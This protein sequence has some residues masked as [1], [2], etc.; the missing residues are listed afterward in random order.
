MNELTEF[1]QQVRQWLEQNCPVSMRGAAALDEIYRGGSRETFSSDEAKLWFER[2]LDKGWTAPGWPRKYGGADLS[3][4]QVKVLKQEM[5]R[6]GC[7]APLEAGQGLAMLG[8]ALLEFGTEQQKLEHLPRI[9]RGE[10]RWCQ[11]YSEPGAGSD[12]ANVQCRAKDMGDHFLIN[13]TKIWTSNADVADWIFCLVRTD[14][15]AGKQEGISFL[16]VDMAQPGVSVKPIELISG[17]S[18]FCQV[19]LDDVRAEKHNLIGEINQGW[20]VGKRLLQ[21]ER[22]LMSEIGDLSMGAASDLPECA[23]LYIGLENGK[24]AESQLRMRV[25]Q[26]EM[27]SQVL[28]LAQRKAFEEAKSGRVN[29]AATSFFK[30]YAT[31]QQSVR[32]ELMLALMGER[33]LGWEHKRMDVSSF[34]DQEL[35]VTRNWAFSKALTIAGGSSEIQLNVIAKRVLGLPDR[36]EGANKS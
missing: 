19:F 9:A 28:Q 17:D 18:D 23:R 4:Q 7:R 8:P 32:Y 21:H 10:V 30:Y 24:L 5:K 3:D 13:G 35:S 20:T 12:L 36:T 25:A 6:L 27:N 11:G 22:T 31:E 26:S 16:L 29:P 2:M 1:R 15:D 14:P 34:E 33:A